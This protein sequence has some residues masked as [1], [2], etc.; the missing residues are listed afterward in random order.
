MGQPFLFALVCVGDRNSLVL[1]AV[2]VDDLL[3][4]IA[5]DDDQLVGA[6][7]DELVEAVSEQRPPIDFDHPLGLVVGE[8]AETR[9]SPG[10]EYDCLHTLTV[11]VKQS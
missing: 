1:V 10:G 3:F 2:V 8:R 6:E 5:D 9:P 7:V 4:H 11:L